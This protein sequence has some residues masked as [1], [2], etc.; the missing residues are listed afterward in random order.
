MP[1]L[2]L[3]GLGA[4]FLYLWISRRRSSLTRLC[5]W[6]LDRAGRAGAFP[7]RRLRG[8]LRSA[9]GPAAAPVSAARPVQGNRI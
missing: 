3:L 2:F 1:L 8:D 6:R 7:L 5:L 9:C 4:V